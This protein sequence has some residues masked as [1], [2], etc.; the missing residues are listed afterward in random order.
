MK[1]EMGV[2]NAT[3]GFVEDRSSGPFW[4]QLGCNGFIVLDGKGGIL[5][6][7]TAAF[8]QLRTLAFTNLEFVLDQVLAGEDVPAAGPGEGVKIAGLQSEA[9]KRLN[10]RRGFCVGHAPGSDG[11]TRLLIMSEGRTLKIRP[12]NVVPSPATT[13]REAQE[14]SVAATEALKMAEAGV[15]GA[16][17]A[18]AAAEAALDGG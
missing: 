17:A 2:K 16:A 9:G 3:I 14:D 4:G 1:M 6:P 10:G 5:K 13:R 8:M 18:A 7:K 12:R 15:A 11:A